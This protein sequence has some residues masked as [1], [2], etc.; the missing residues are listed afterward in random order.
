MD[1]FI[2]IPDQHVGYPLMLPDAVER[3]AQL[4]DEYSPFITPDMMVQMQVA[5]WRALRPGL[6]LGSVPSY[7]QVPTTGQ[8]VRIPRKY[9]LRHLDDILPPVAFL[10][11]PEA[12]GA[13]PVMEGCPILIWEADLDRWKKSLPKI[14]ND[15]EQI[16]QQGRRKATNMEVAAWADAAVAAGFRI[17]TASEAV[18][19]DWPSNRIPLT[20]DSA[21]EALKAAQVRAGVPV[22]RG[23]PKKS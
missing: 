18:T 8:Y 6:A 12:I 10:G 19:A 16:D 4:A 21:A 5:T 17:G 14:E 15:S 2:H 11:M 3:A 13:D 22:S 23:R 9:W 1:A 7:L 20:K